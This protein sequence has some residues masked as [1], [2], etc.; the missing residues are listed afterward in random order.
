MKSCLV[1]AITLSALLVGC[2]PK[3]WHKDGA[4]Q[5][6]YKRDELACEK[7]ANS[8]GYGRNVFNICMNSR[9]Y[10]LKKRQTI[11]Q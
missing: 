1:Y 6:D 11:Q 8:A 5:N 4:T 9:G 2:A 7:E 10:S 3:T